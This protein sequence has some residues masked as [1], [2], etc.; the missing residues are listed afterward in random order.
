MSGN[1]SGEDMKNQLQSILIPLLD[2][3][4]PRICIVCGKRLLTFEK[5]ICTC[6]LSDLPLTFNWAL[7][8]NTMAD[9]FNELIQRSLCH[10]M[11]D[12]PAATVRT[13]YSR[14]TAL[15]FFNSEASY[16]KIPYSI[17]YRRDIASGLFFGHMLGDKIAGSGILRDIDMIVPVPLFWT[18]R[19]KRGYNQAEVIAGG[20]ASSLKVPLCTD[21]LYR[22]HCTATQTRLDVREK[23]L[24]VKDAFALR[25]G[26]P[27]GTGHILLVDDVFTTGAT[28]HAC[29]QAVRK[30]RKD[31]LVSIATLAMVSN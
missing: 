17:K 19:W 13:P 11:E 9:K 12:V 3:V 15:F 1:I 30:A 5:H 23:A 27:P 26:F 28:L 14:A 31:I 18:R 25:K 8:H 29:Y 16:R 20:I 7:P 10:E 4:L 22:R 24:N 21:I 6:C 2:L